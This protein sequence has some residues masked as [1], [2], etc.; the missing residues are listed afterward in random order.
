M[1]F[2][3]N[4]K[5]LISDAY[6][7]QYAEITD[8]KE[9]QKKKKPKLFFTYS[10]WGFIIM[11]LVLSAL[12]PCGFSEPFAGYIISG[13]SLFIGVFFTFLIT[14]YDKFQNIDFTVY[15]VQ[16]GDRKNLNGI[17]LKNFFKKLTVLSL[18]SVL[19]SILLI[20]LLSLSLLFI[21]VFDTKVEIIGILSNIK[22]TP[23][24]IILKPIGIFIYR[25]LVFYFLLDFILISVFV[26]SSYYD[27][28]ISEI[29]N[30]KLK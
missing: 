13:L 22:E 10:Q 7:F 19:L 8:T 25:S 11:S 27:F 28:F 18:Y 4:I 14:L 30:K 6:R 20:I 9:S 3:K 5:D 21:D 16:N 29:N 15:Q 1:N 17:K 2:R 23:V 12:L 24:R 26:I